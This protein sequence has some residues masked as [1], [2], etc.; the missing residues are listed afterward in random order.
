MANIAGYKGVLEA[1]NLYGRFLG[2]QVTAAGK[3]PPSKVLVIGAGVGMYPL[4]RTRDMLTSTQLVYLL[5]Q[6]LKEPERSSE[7]SILELR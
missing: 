7:A 5:L 1:S 4:A 6:L 3:V 2:G